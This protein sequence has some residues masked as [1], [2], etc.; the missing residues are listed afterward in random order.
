MER[1]I[2]D[3]GGLTLIIS[4]NLAAALAADGI[5][6][7]ERGGEWLLDKGDG[8]FEPVALVT[9][10]TALV[11]HL[12]RSIM[13]VRAAGADAPSGSPSAEWWGDAL[14][15]PSTL[16]REALDLVAMGGVR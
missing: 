4:D 16:C 7:D 8:C 1:H 15:A 10:R 12:A 3:H 2:T 11:V 9:V 5:R 6:Y 14:R 13:A